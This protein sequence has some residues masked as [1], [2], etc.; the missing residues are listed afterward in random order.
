MFVITLTY[1][2]PLDEV[3]PHIPAHMEWL[4]KHYEAGLLLASGRQVPR[5]GGVM[6]AGTTTRERVEEFVAGDPFHVNGLADYEIVEFTPSRTA[7]GL[8][9][10]LA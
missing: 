5:T 6:L 3:D 9:Q 8:Q 10:L 2:V 7:P 4:D 1:K